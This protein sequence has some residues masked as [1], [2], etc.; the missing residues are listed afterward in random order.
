MLKH[1]SL[2]YKLFFQLINI[3]HLTISNIELS[4]GSFPEFLKH[5]N[6]LLLHFSKVF[7]NQRI[8]LHHGPLLKL[9]LVQEI[10]K[11]INLHR[12]FR[13]ENIRY[14]QCEIFNFVMLSEITDKLGNEMSILNNQTL[15]MWLE[16]LAV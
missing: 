13:F 9:L 15:G 4:R 14:D 12:E 6:L 10:L 16:L 2:I 1:D 3:K 5:S 11:L 7:D 8:N